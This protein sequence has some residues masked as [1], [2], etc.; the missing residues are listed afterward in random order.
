[1]SAKSMMDGAIPEFGLRVS[2]AT[3]SD[4]PGAYAI[5]SGW[6][7]P[8]RRRSGL[9]ENIVVGGISWLLVT[10]AHA[11]TDEIQVY[12]ADINSPGRLC[13]NKATCTT[14]STIAQITTDE[15]FCK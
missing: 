7:R 14:I 3:Y 5:L 1:M 2:E 13:A 15:A 11:Q 4:R 9:V 12:D 10:G 6:V 8:A